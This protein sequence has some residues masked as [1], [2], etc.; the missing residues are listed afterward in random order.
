MLARSLVPLLCA[1]AL[2]AQ[3]PSAWSTLTVPGGVDPTKITTSDK[4]ILYRDAGYLRVFSAVT[5]QWHAF[6]PSP[7]TT[8]TLEDD[9]L[10]TPESDRWTAFSAYRG[11][12]LPLFVDYWTSSM[13]SNESVAVVD[14]GANVHAF[15]AFTGA[16]HS[17]AK[18][19]NAIVQLGTRM[20]LL[21]STGT[22]TPGFASAFDAFSGTWHDV[23]PQ[24]DNVYG[25]RLAGGTCMV[26]FGP[27]VYGF[28]N[29]T[30]G[31]QHI[32]ATP[33]AYPPNNSPYG[34]ATGLRGTFYSGATGRFTANLGSGH[35][36]ESAYQIGTAYDQG[37][38]HVTSAAHD[39]WLAM[40]AGATLRSRFYATAV[41]ST[42]GFAHLYSGLTHSALTVAHDF[43]FGSWNRRGLLVALRAPVTDAPQVFNAVSGQLHAPPAD[44][45]PGLPWLSR[46]S[47]G[48]YTAG[49]VSAF[50]SF[51][52]SWHPL[53]APTALLG[54]SD[55]SLLTATDADDVHVFDGN[56]DRWRSLPVA[57]AQR[58]G[59]SLGRD[60]LVTGD[61]VAATGFSTVS[62]E[63][64]SV[65]L[66]EPRLGHGADGQ[67]AHV[68]TQN[69]LLAFTGYGDLTVWNA[70]PSDFS[71][72]GDGGKTQLQC[73]T[74]A[75]PILV[76]GLSPRG[77]TPLPTPFGDVWLV[78]SQTVTE[79]MVPIVG[80]GR[81]RLE[82]QLPPSPSLKNTTWTA[83]TLTLP[84]G[85]AA[86]TSAAVPLHIL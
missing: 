33:P 62:G 39:S 2:A 43:D 13:Q 31:W 9:V 15:S 29:M 59:P 68:Y 42:T 61:D 22:T 79:V 23:P 73:R 86:W 6:T 70:F 46:I 47:A 18:P 56:R 30:G 27:D 53:A 36:V 69:H 1:G 67:C 48:V 75:F 45:L 77:T 11:T 57:A 76:L 81:A 28:S 40:P 32:G 80:E 5:G 20:V 50:S 60:T 14:D 85:G 38:Y 52:G 58:F 37:T 49:G 34:E 54:A 8:V 19:A 10:L 25:A 7:G 3:A 66:P 65:V 71:P 16:W 55:G 26:A 72:L 63:P 78:P 44:A 84:F 4:L 21:R 64:E 51:G 24:T 41:F 35:G 12:F 83:Q 82:L 17:R 74:P